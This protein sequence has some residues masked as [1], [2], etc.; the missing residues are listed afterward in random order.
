MYNFRGGA[1][2]LRFNQKL[3][4]N[5]L[6]SQRKKNNSDNISEFGAATAALT[7]T[8]SISSKRILL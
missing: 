1:G 4:N 3:L 8:K 6:E 2:L 7:G 5:L